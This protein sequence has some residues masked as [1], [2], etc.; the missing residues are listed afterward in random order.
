MVIPLPHQRIT[1]LVHN[2][3]D[4]LCHNVANRVKMP[5]IRPYARYL[6]TITNVFKIN[7][8]NQSGMARFCSRDCAIEVKPR[9]NSPPENTT[10]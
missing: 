9:R 1:H 6:P 10:P 5:E 3:M 2:G 8:F 4:T 7:M